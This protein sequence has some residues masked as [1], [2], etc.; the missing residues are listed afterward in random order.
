MTDPLK[1]KVAIVTGSDSGM[2]QAMAEAFAQEDADVAITNLH[3]RQ[4]AEETRKKN[5]GRR[6]QGHRR[7]LRSAKAG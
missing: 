4:G 3:D 2:G 7:S 5:R 6:S 1:D